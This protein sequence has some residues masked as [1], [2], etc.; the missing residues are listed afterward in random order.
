MFYCIPKYTDNNSAI[1]Y[2][3]TTTYFKIKDK[4]YVSK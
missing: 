3:I 1:Y 4:Q 2:Y